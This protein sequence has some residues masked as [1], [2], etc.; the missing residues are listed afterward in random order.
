MLYNTTRTN[1][2][3]FING[4]ILVYPTEAHLHPIQRL[5]KLELSL[6]VGL[7]GGG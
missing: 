4:N 5:L 7:C 1:E 6:L 2:H 3:L